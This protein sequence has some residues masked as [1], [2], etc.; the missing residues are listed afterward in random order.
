M[1][2]W[3]A[4]WPYRRATL[5]DLIRGGQGGGGQGGGGAPGTV[6]VIRFGSDT[7]EHVAAD[8][9]AAAQAVGFDEPLK[10]Q[11]Q[12]GKRVQTQLRAAIDAATAWREPTLAEQEAQSRKRSAHLAKLVAKLHQRQLQ[13]RLGLRAPLPT[14]F[15][16]GHQEFDY[17]K[18][19]AY[20]EADIFKFAR[21]EGIA[22]S[23]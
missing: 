9:V 18:S 8:V 19:A 20:S 16:S 22:G 6:A 13:R 11:Q 1:S 5:I 4:G 17:I 2:F 21:Q 15:E 3:L 14:M 12:D 23:D 10:Q 7:L